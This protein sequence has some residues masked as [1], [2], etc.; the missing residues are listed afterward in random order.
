MR[1]LL[2]ALL[3]SL[4]VLLIAGAGLALH[5]WL[6]RDR[7][8]SEPSGSDG[9]PLDSTR[10]PRPGTGKKANVETEI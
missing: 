8:R 4:V 1:W 10:N 6:Q 7:T 9:Q 3:V 5:I 2:I